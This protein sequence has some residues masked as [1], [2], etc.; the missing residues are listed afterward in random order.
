MIINDNKI[1][2]NSAQTIGLRMAKTQTK[3]KYSSYIA[4]TGGE[5][6]ERDIEEKEGK[7]GRR[8]TRGRDQVTWEAG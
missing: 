1:K 2:L 8:E 7:R 6:K 4:E 5:E 3:R